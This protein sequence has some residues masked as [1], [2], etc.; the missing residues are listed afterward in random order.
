M[1]WVKRLIWIVAAI[2]G[3]SALA[4][5]AAFQLSPRIQDTVF[6]SGSRVQL[7]RESQAPFDDDALRVVLCGT[8][9]PLPLRRSAK[10]CTLV[11]AGG[12][13]FLVDIGP[14]ASE[15]LALWRIP[16]PRVGAVFLTHFHSDHIGELGEF[17]VQ[18]WAQGRREPLAVY[19]PEGVDQVVAGFN[20]AYA[21]DRGYRHAHHDRGRGL[22]PLE[23]AQMQAQPIALASLGE[24]PTGRTIIVYE[25]DGLVVT[26]IEI[27]HRPVAPAFSYRFDYRG[28]SVV[29]T[30]DTTYFPPLAEGARGAD[31]L[32]S[33]A[34]ATHLQDIV[35]AEAQALG[36]ATLAS[37][38]RDTNDYHITPVQA[39][40]LANQAGVRELVYTHVAPPI[41]FPLIETPWM[42]GVRDV[43]P[44]GVRI[45]HDGLMI[46]IPIDGGDVQFTKL[47]G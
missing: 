23:A 19:G 12:R 20:A 4:G 37:V 22:L 29:I 21:L 10:A 1:V 30:G 26:A 27:D 44:R 40:E 34:Q 17:N 11:I 5:L 36:E 9:S 6:A 43:R 15:N 42:R 24:P 3:A 46:T 13:L 31:V 28:R 7:S 8:S 14:E 45:G 16:T 47:R 35:A 33:E 2:I 25:Q 41:A 32:I 39:A 38:L 18:G